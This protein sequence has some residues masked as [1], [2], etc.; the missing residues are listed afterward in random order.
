[1]ENPWRMPLED[2]YRDVVLLTAGGTTMASATL[3]RGAP[4]AALHHVH[5]TATP[6]PGSIRYGVAEGVQG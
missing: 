4:E 1:M 5:Y 3:A 2:H 6:C